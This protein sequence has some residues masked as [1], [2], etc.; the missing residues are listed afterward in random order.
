MSSGL[1]TIIVA[2][3]FFEGRF[4]CVCEPSFRDGECSIVITL[5]AVSH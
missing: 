1:A 3:A 5:D 4:Q 2:H